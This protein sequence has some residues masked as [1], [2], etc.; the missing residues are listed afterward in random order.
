MKVEKALGN[1]KSNGLDES[2]SVWRKS[3]A[4]LD[5]ESPIPDST[6][7]AICNYI[8]AN[9]KDSLTCLDAVST[10]TIPK[11]P[12]SDDR[13]LIKTLKSIDSVE[14]PLNISDIC[15]R[16]GKIDFYYLLEKYL[17]TEEQLIE[18]A[19]PMKT[20]MQGVAEIKVRPS[21]TEPHDINPNAKRH[22][23]ARCGKNFIIMNNGSYMR[24]EECWYHHGK[25]YSQKVGGEWIAVFSCCQ[26][27]S[28]NGCQVADKHVTN[29]ENPAKRTGFTILQQP[30]EGKEN[31]VFAL[32]C[33]MVYTSIGLELARVS[34]IDHNHNTVYDSFVK[35]YNQVVDYNTRFSGITEQT[36][37]GTL[38]NLK[39]VQRFLK[40]IMF[41]DSILLGHSLES[42]LKA[43]KIIH[44]KV[45]DTAI[46]FPHRKGG[47]YKR[48]LSTLT[49]EYL[50]KIIQDD[51][52]GHDSIEDAIACIEL[53]E[54]QISQD[55]NRLEKGKKL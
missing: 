21:S 33:E 55:R 49:R 51:E 1:S 25:A 44:N 12:I 8:N 35:P 48:A 3:T 50:E 36:L 27:S 5:L 14:K 20:S 34:V 39:Q 43:L 11:S 30:L 53:M 19:Y 23:C 32:D 18:N 31:S 7:S 28:F 22:C 40:Q 47:T 38:P 52:G 4:N 15:S 54:L 41:Q 9:S 29:G 24:A 10:T 42:D 16:S 6:T 46:V 17:L 26:S 37:T 13:E 45:V 2:K